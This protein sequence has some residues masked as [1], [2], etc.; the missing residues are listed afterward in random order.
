MN[1]LRFGIVLATVL[2]VSTTADKDVP[3][4]AAMYKDSVNLTCRSEDFDPDRHHTMM[5]LLPNGDLVKKTNTNDRVIFYEE[6]KHIM[7]REVDDVDFGIYN[8]IVQV[9]GTENYVII[10]KGININGP[11]WGDLGK[12]YRT[13]FI[14]GG[15]AAAAVCALM[16][17]MCYCMNHGQTLDAEEAER[18]KGTDLWKSNTQGIDNMGVELQSSTH[19]ETKK[20]PLDG[21]SVPPEYAEPVKQATKL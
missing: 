3:N 8:C 14:V 12:K 11:Y 6:G 15:I 17:G 9:S 2:M 13:N 18:L 19:S 21:S 1:I 5:W 10:Q 20:V 16:I 7:V 4:T